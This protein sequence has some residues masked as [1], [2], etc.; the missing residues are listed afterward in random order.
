MQ[1]LSKHKSPS[2]NP[3]LKG[4]EEKW[5][6]TKNLPTPPVGVGILLLSVRVLGMAPLFAGRDDLLGDRDFTVGHGDDRR[7]SSGQGR[8]GLDRLVV[9]F[10]EQCIEAG[11]LRLV[12]GEV[13][14]VLDREIEVLFGKPLP[15]DD[16][17]VV[18]LGGRAMLQKRIVVLPRLAAVV[19]LLGGGNDRWK[20]LL[21]EQQDRVQLLAL[22]AVA[23]RFGFLLQRREL[24]GLRLVGLGLVV[25]GE[26]RIL[27]DDRVE[28]A[29]GVAGDGEEDHDKRHEE[30]LHSGNSGLQFGIARHVWLLSPVCTGKI[31]GCCAARLTVR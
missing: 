24:R 11:N 6:N 25:L 3:S 20:R 7:R 9:L 13:H 18:G 15:P 5:C 4:G 16:L 31:F 14:V 23:E 29:A 2:P 22:V 28:P 12:G 19:G 10:G 1:F 17:L 27:L 26:G 30:R 8:D 21:G